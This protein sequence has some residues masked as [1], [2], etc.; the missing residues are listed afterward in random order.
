VGVGWP[1][2][3]ARK[4]GVVDRSEARILNEGRFSILVG[5]ALGFACAA[6]A[7]VS[8]LIGNTCILFG[9]VGSVFSEVR[10]KLHADGTYEQQTRPG[11]TTR[12][13]WKEENGKLCYTQSDP[14]PR[15]GA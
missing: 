12:G 1:G 2:N 6:Y 13:I 5:A 8:G 4:C 15:P 7:D 14:K 9:N 10:V 3:S 11:G